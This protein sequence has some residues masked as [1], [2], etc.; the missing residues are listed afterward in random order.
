[1]S[2]QK[3]EDGEQEV[4]V[5]LTAADNMN[6]STKLVTYKTIPALDRLI[7]PADS[8]YGKF[9]ISIALYRSGKLEWGILGQSWTRNHW[10]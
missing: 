7:H 3:V 10:G 8:Q 2:G 9:V 4:I 5:S 1:M 6:S